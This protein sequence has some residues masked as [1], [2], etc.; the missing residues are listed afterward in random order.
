[1]DELVTFKGFVL[2]FDTQS[3]LMNTRMDEKKGKRNERAGLKFLTLAVGTFCF[4]K[5][6]LRLISKTT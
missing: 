1:M 5:Q 3:I 4:S 6:N 2:K